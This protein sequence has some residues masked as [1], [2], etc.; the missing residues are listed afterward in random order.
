VRAIVFNLG[1]LPQADRAVTTRPATTIAALTQALDLIA[2]G[3][4]VTVMAYRG[5]AAGVAEADAVRTLAAG[6]GDRFVVTL[7]ARL[8]TVAPTPELSVFERLV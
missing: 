3:G 1:Y 4:R 6:C 5:H 8:G 2:A 7:M